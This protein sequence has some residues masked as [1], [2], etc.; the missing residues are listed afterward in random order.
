MTGQHTIYIIGAGAIGKALAVFL[1]LNQQEVVLV[2]GSTDDNTSHFETIN[3][4]LP[5]NTT[6]GATVA[7][8]SLSCFEKLDGVV[9]LTNKSY[10]NHRLSQVL[11]RKVG[12]APIVIL[13]NGLAVEQPFVDAGFSQIYRCVLFA[14]SLQ[15]SADTLRFR[16]VNTSQIGVVVGN[17]ERAKQIAGALHNAYFPFAAEENIQPIIWTKAIVNSVFNSVCPLLETD[18]GIFYRDEQ[19]LDIA[20]RVI[21]ECVAI[22]G[23]RGIVLDAEKVISTLLTIS[24]SSDGQ[25]IST[26]QDI[27]HKRK[28]EIDTLNFAI[29]SMANQS[30]AWDSVRATKLLG[31][32]VK[33]KSELTMAG[34]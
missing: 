25:L 32:L 12:N 6:V 18:N 14:T 23:Q 29:V 16:P 3:I 19:A 10:G 21:G 24:Q 13:Q 26:Y 7:I 11:Q 31:E 33:L 22:A 9:V 17:F 4:V 5:D 8:S 15:V 30:G 28:T 34:L 20:K 1:K 2:R 27:K